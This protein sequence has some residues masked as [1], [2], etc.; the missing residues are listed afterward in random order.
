MIKG[1]KLPRTQRNYRYTTA[2]ENMGH[3]HVQ[4]KRNNKTV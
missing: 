3:L 4:Q 1:A 2:K